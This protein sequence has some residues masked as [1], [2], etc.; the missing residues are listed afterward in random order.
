MAIGV[1]TRMTLI[2][3]ATPM[4]QKRSPNPNDPINNPSNVSDVN[5]VGVAAAMD[6]I[7]DKRVFYIV[8]APMLE[9]SEIGI[10]GLDLGRAVS[11]QASDAADLVSTL[12]KIDS[13]IR[14][15]NNVPTFVTFTS[16]TEL[17]INPSST[18]LHSNGN[19][20][21]YGISVSEGS[22]Q[23]PAWIPSLEIRFRSTSVEHSAFMI[24]RDESYT[25]KFN[26]RN[27]FD[28]VSFRGR[29]AAALDQLKSDGM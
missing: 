23:E 1:E 16:K 10:D 8:L 17:P 9:H 22:L 25:E 4:K 29:I 5:S 7:K 19:G 14:S 15:T 20:S 26:F 6:R 21:I 27:D 3:G 11:I 2:P 18:T 12:D 13:A 28:V 24:L